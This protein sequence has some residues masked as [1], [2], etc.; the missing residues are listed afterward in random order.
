MRGETGLNKRVLFDWQDWFVYIVLLA[1]IVIFARLNPFFF[2]AQN[3]ESIGRQT[4]MV[5]IIAMGATFVITTGNIDLS[6][7]AIVGLVGVAAASYLRAGLG[8]FSAS[9]FGIA[10]GAFVGLI[11]G[12][13]VAKIQIP[14]FLVTL[15]TMGIARGIALTVTNTK[16]VII[17][18]ANFTR[19][20]G[21]G[22]FLGL[23]TSILWT[24][25][26]F[27]LTFWLYQFT[28]FGN[29]VKAVGGNKTAAAFS[30]VRIERTTIYVFVMAGILS[31]I[32]GLLMAARLKS[33]RPEVGNGLELDA[34]AAVILGG[35]ALSGGRGKMVNTLVGSLLMGVIINGL[36]IMGVQSNVQ[37]II[38]GAII[39]GAVSLSKNKS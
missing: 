8:I 22:S 11:N 27:A 2:T 6:C 32:A 38:K 28:I 34:V 13:L 23:P 25:L 35:T 15:G 9:L 26:F 12:L 18:D 1:L 20:W 31:A 19:F 30:G 37:E 21:A 4:A 24:V 36:I 29:Y 3:F 5:S 14:A 17:M 16:A 10:I 33:G 7:G 39:I